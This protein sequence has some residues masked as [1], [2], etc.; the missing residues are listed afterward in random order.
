MIIVTYKQRFEY[1]DEHY[2]ESTSIYE[3]KS[4]LIVELER[5]KNVEYPMIILGLWEVKSDLTYSWK[6]ILLQRRTLRSCAR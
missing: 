1:V 3:N 5:C 6:Q 4:D 2:I